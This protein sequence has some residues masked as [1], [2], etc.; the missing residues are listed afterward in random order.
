MKLKK[1]A[2]VLLSTVMAIS[3]AGCSSGAGDSEKTAGQNDKGKAKTITALVQQSLQ[4][5][6][7]RDGL[8]N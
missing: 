6:Q 1:I 4:I 8:V 3:V 5:C 7:T 2:E